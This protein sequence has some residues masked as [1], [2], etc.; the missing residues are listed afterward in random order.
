MSSFP[1]GKEVVYQPSRALGRVT[2]HLPEGGWTLITSFPDKEGDPEVTR[3][4]LDDELL[5]VSDHDK[6]IQAKRTPVNSEGKRDKRGDTR[7]TD[8]AEGL[9]RT[10]SQKTRPMLGRYAVATTSIK[11]GVELLRVRPVAAIV[12]DQFLEK[13]VCWHCFDSPESFTSC[14][15]CKVARFCDQDCRSAAERTHRWTCKAFMSIIRRD[16]PVSHPE[17]V[18][19]VIDALAR[20]KAGL[21]ADDLWD[22]F[23][24][25]E[26]GNPNKDDM[27][28]ARHA[29]QDIRNTVSADL[30]GEY[31]EKDIAMAFI[32]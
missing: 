23:L 8:Q 2:R 29:E 3:W 9:L 4:A 25:L 27:S 7:P 16:P 12:P 6:E 10:V 1:I 15:A 19:L 17:N 18:R 30:V 32:R 22:R 24:S 11:P 5:L 20:R 14:P 13:K 31:T 21:V 28:E 26:V